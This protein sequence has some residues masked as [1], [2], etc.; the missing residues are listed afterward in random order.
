[1]TQSFKADVAFKW[2]KWDET[3]FIKRGR[4]WFSILGIRN[5]NSYLPFRPCGIA[6]VAENCSD[7]EN[8][9]HTHRRYIWMAEMRR[10]YFFMKLLCHLLQNWSSFTFSPVWMRRWL[11]YVT[12]W[13][14]PRP[15]SSHLYGVSF[16]CTRMCSFKFV[17]I[18]K[19]NQKKAI[20]FV[21][22]LFIWSMVT[23]TLFEFFITLRTR[24]PILIAMRKHVHFVSTDLCKWFAA[25][26]TCVRSFVRVCS[27]G[28]KIVHFWIFSITSIWPT[29]NKKRPNFKITSCALDMFPND[30]IFSNKIHMYMAD[31]SY[32]L[33]CEIYRFSYRKM[34]PHISRYF[35]RQNCID[36][37][38]LLYVLFWISNERIWLELWWVIKWLNAKKRQIT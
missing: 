14:K 20:I 18:I 31:R 6:N 19:K 28:W 30:W 7:D 3:I 12:S 29:T 8:S 24:E 37:G 17:A 2:L 22:L 13:A 34:S 36:M 10:R 35:H 15:Q 21:F 9:Y 32:A 1:M 16:V 4:R 5:W 11:R 25:Q 27:V 33:S 26:M 38:V 23:F